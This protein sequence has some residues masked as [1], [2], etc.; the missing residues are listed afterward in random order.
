MQGRN[1]PDEMPEVSL[2]SLRE[3]ANAP[4]GAIRADRLLVAA[5]MAASN[6]EARRLLSQGAVEILPASDDPYRLESDRAEVSPAAGDVLRAG[7]RRF[8]RIIAP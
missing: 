5:G 6:A 8:V 7:R 1:L 2:A 3:Q 4:D